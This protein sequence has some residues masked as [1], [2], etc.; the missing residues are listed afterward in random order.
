MTATLPLAVVGCDFR[1]APASARSMLVL[2]SEDQK[3][4]A[5]NLTDSTWA[6]G[7]AFLNTC[8]RNE[9]LVSSEDPVWAADLL[10][11]RM[12]QLLPPALRAE[13]TPYTYIGE[14]AA[15]HIFRVALGQES[16]VVGERQIAGQLFKSLTEA[17]KG[18][19]S[20]R[21]L[22]ELES[23]TGKLMRVAKHLGCLQASSVGAHSLAISWLREHLPIDSRRVAVVGMGAIGRLAWTSLNHDPK[24]SVVALNRTIHSVSQT[25]PLTELHEVLQNVDAA[26]FCTASRHPIYNP[27]LCNPGKPLIVVDLGIP[28]QVVGDCS[29]TQ[30]Q[31][32]GFDELV[33][34]NQS[35]DNGNPDNNQAVIEEMVSRALVEYKRT[36]SPP[37]LAP[38]INDVRSRSRMLLRTEMRA[39]LDDR[40]SDMSPDV[41]AA[42]EGDLST[43][44]AEYTNDILQT[45]SGGVKVTSQEPR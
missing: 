42:I 45:I 5:R 1:I 12:Q 10:K 41:R 13:V 36:S 16:L 21:N 23:R 7:I 34:W 30:V 19:H 40:L 2:S 31:R 37:V 17:R 18:G 33:L 27:I 24:F 25:K 44:L 8:N 4:L 22:N 6:D 26:I 9:W 29:G 11:S 32:V 38:F 35:K 14:E 28:E 39:L 20:A 15:R 3:T 43:L